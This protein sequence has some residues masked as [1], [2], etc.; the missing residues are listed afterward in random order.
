MSSIRRLL[1]QHRC[2]E[3]TRLIC[4]KTAAS[5]VESSLRARACENVD[6]METVREKHGGASAMCVLVGAE[7]NRC[8]RT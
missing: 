4:L 8:E 6:E 1:S 2:A 7:R 5:L 3:N